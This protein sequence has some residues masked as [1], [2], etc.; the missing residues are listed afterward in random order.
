MG[1]ELI[2]SNAKGAEIIL[3]KSA[4]AQVTILPKT[5]ALLQAYEVKHDKVYF[6]C[7]DGL[8]DIANAGKEIKEWYKSAKLSPFP[9]R[10]E[11]AVYSFSD[12]EY[13]F[14]NKFADG[15]AIHGLLFDQPFEIVSQSILDH[16]ASVTL[17]HCYRGKDP[18]YPFHY[19]CY[20]TYSLGDDNALTISTTIANEEVTDIPV[21]DGWHPYFNLGGTTDEWTL[22]VNSEKKL[23]LT[24]KMVPNGETVAAGFTQPVSLK[25]INLDDCFLIPQQVAATLFNPVN[26]WS[27]KFTLL[28][29]Y[30]YLQIFTPDHRKSIAI[31]PFSAAPNS[32]NNEIGLIKLPVGEEITFIWKIHLIHQSS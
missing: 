26:R 22:S 8:S 19:D 6:N 11:N 16:S 5:G 14:Q 9:A 25:D 13:S 10:I 17:Q 32:F 27:V 7:I 21:A 23:V 31:E 12:R 24:E 29:N 18:G 30:P 2:T 4:N 28:Q 3:L 1:F 20:V 15:S